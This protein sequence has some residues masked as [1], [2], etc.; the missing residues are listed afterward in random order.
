MEV[1]L[2]VEVDVALRRP[3]R[4]DKRVWVW[5]AVAD[6]PHAGTTA[7]ELACQIAAATPGVV[8]PVGARV[9][10]WVEEPAAGQAS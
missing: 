2:L 7:E 5:V 8:M 6:G 1:T 10:D 4:A 9:I 3:P